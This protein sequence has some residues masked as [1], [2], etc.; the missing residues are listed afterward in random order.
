[1]AGCEPSNHQFSTIT[2]NSDQAAMIRSLYYQVIGW[3]SLILVIVIV[4]LFLALFVYSRR[5]TGEKGPPVRA[6][7]HLGLEIAWTAGPALILMLIA[8]PAIRIGF[9]TQPS[10]PPPDAITVKVIA[11]QWWWEIR[12]PQL[13][14]TT[15]NE[16]HIPVNKP[17]RFDL[18]SAD[19]I[20]SFWIPRLAGRRDVIPGHQN[21]V[22]L[23]PRVV[24]VFFGE[25]AEFCGLSH[26]NMYFRVFVD[27]DS[28]FETWRAA[29]ILPATTAAP[30]DPRLAA[31]ARVFAAS[32]CTACHGIKGVSKGTIGPDLT[33]F[34][35]RTTLAAGMMEN[36]LRNLSTWLTNPGAIKPG[37]QMPNLGLGPEQT[38]QLAAYLESLK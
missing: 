33:H 13:G 25:C 9:R 19:V 21:E 6:A 35:S 8:I 32:P 2:D 5:V 22:T 16:I 28:G 24:G 29:N 17:V 14:I 30:L 36:S 34:G 37:A 38:S 12:Y 11:H 26:A 23:M 15:A 4:T 20:H 3:D 7:E 31:G 27:T 10:K 18:E 1:L